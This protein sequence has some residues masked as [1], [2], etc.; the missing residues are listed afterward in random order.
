MFRDIPDSF[1]ERILCSISEPALIF[2]E[3]R[4]ICW[5]NPAAEILLGHSSGVLCGKKCAQIF[6]NPECAVSCP[7]D[8]AFET[9]TDQTLEVESLLQSDRL[10]EAIPYGRNRTRFVL[11]II[12]PAEE[13][14]RLESL[15]R[16]LAAALNS[17]TTLREA[18]VD[19]LAA[20]E[21]LA[22]IRR[23]GIYTGTG[24]KLVL[25]SGTSV[26]QT[27]SRHTEKPGF[28]RAANLSDG[29]LTGFPDGIAL[30]P[31]AGSS[32][33]PEVFLAAGRGR[34]GSESRRILELIAEVLSSCVD[35]LAAY[36]AS[37]SL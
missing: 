25:L 8:K 5:V 24:E 15:R 22:S 12:H 31:V 13:K 20:M 1:A 23:K 26:P 21:N 2:N 3:N 35:R 14:D 6:N 10:V 19:V 11:S 33:N 34:W 9:G 32:G 37:S 27:I 36:E 16:D 29:E 7:V 4:D 18:A 30:I 28:V 17:R